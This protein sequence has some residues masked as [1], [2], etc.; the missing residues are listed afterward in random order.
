MGILVIGGVLFGMILG[1]FFM[2]NV[3]VP[4]CGLV[5]VLALVYPADVGHSLLSGFLH[6]YLLT[7]SLQIGYVIGLFA[8]C[9]K[10]GCN[11]CAA[12]AIATTQLFLSI[13]I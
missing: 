10:V 4:A 1:Q 5:I 6:I 7:T 2:W 9:F 12:A 13:C 3:L 11:R 8:R